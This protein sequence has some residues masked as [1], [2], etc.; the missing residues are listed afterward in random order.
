MS[1]GVLSANSM[2]SGQFYTQ[3]TLNAE[4]ASE[5]YS[6]IPINS[7]ITQSEGN[8]QP[9]TTAGYTKEL[10]S[11][12]YYLNQNVMISVN[13]LIAFKTKLLSDVLSCRLFMNTY[14]LLI[15]HILR[16][17][18]FFNGLLMKL[19]NGVDIRTEKDFVEQEVFWNRIMAEHAKFIRGLLDPT[20]VDLFH[21]A[22]MFGNEFDALYLESQ[23]AQND[24]ALIPKTTTDSLAATQKIRDFKAAGTSGLLQCKIKSMIIPLLGDHVLREANHFLFILEKGSA[25]I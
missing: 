3:F 9:R 10:E 23:K 2:N 6:G 11:K 5:Y 20:E 1:N 7:T 25:G 14:P 22:D 17:A 15:D 19:Q 18:H 12:V 13:A 8:I 21:T 24:A 4:H 16:E